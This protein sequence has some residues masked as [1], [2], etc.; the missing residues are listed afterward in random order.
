MTPQELLAHV[1][2]S[3]SLELVSFLGLEANKIRLLFLQTIPSQEANK[4][5]QEISVALAKKVLSPEMI[6]TDEIQSLY[7]H[8]AFYFKKTNN[9]AYVDNCTTYIEET[10]FKKRL[11]A[12]LHHKRYTTNRSH[13]T[14]FKNY[15]RKLSVART[16]LNEDYTY[17]VLKD[18]Y[19]YRH[20][21][22]PSLPEDIQNDVISMF[23]SE[24]LQLEFP[25]LLEFNVHKLSQLPNLKITEYTGKEYV[26]SILAEEVFKKN[27]LEYRGVRE[28]FGYSI[29][30]ASEIIINR[31]Q[32]D[33]DKGY[34]KLAAT[35]VV[36]L[37]C[38]LNMRMHYYSSLCLYERSGIYNQFYNTAGR[39]KFIDVGCGPGTCGLAFAEY[40][41]D[42]TGESASFDYFGID[43]SSTM[44]E[45]AKQ[46]LSTTTLFDAKVSKYYSDILEIS[47]EELANASCIVINTCYVFASS[48]LSIEGI[49][50]FIKKIGQKYKY[51]PKFLLFQ[52]PISE[53]LNA[54]YELFKTLLVDHASLFEEK[55]EIKYYNQ[56]KLTNKAKERAIQYEILKL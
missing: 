33:F 5:F 43:T 53:T 28:L 6:S 47:M 27:F 55:K 8:L 40:I 37:Y 51:I 38:Y 29:E 44:I 56:R 32:A 14:E 17:E 13:I 41:Y 7:T 12:W 31:G 15:L 23:E 9:R 16:D 21:I 26:P 35:D 45:Q 34:E 49:A 18:L 25:L 10:V 11:S 24:E 20:S 48:T 52:N 54:R 30:N 50:S 46:I 22:I 36:K 2:E 42:S 19:D 39:V 4:T 3:T 1:S